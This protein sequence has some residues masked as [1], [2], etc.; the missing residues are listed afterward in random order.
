MATDADWLEV[1]AVRS[2]SSEPDEWG[3]VVASCSSAEASGDEW[4]SIAAALPAQ[5]SPETDEPSVVV[6]ADT[7]SAPRR[8]RG[9]PRSNPPATERPSDLIAPVS[10]AALCLARMTDL[11]RCW[12]NRGDDLAPCT[13]R[14]LLAR[15]DAPRPDDEM[16]ATRVRGLSRLHP[17]L[18]RLDAAAELGR[19]ACEVGVDDGTLR[20]V[21]QHFLGDDPAR[22]PLDSLAECYGLQRRKIMVALVRAASAVSIAERGVIFDLAAAVVRGCGTNA[23]LYIEAVQYDETPMITTTAHDTTNL[24]EHSADRGGPLVE[25]TTT[26]GIRLRPTPAV[27]RILQTNAT[28]GMVFQLGGRLACIVGR[29][30]CHLQDLE[31]CTSETVCEAQLSISATPIVASAF[32]DKLRAACADKAGCNVAAERGV[33]AARGPEW[34]PLL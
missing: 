12:R 20:L 1:A 11:P 26:L 25:H 13:D 17:L 6:L 32:A 22:L 10:G 4:A 8:R 31:R 7:P 16:Y 18:Q 29:S 14:A 15:V 9:R 5:P 28:Y 21:R 3:D 30:I 33:A 2:V 23:L 24:V 27:T 19:R 34:E